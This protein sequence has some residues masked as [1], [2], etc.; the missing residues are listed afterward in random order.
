M[1]GFWTLS[2]ATGIGAT[3]GLLAL[4]LWPFFP[5]DQ[6]WLGWLFLAA[7]MVAGLCGLSILLITAFDILFHPRRGVRIRPVR[8]FDIVLGAALVA[9]S[10]LQL[11]DFAGQLS[12]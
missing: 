7:S 9:L 5:S 8:A 4:L 11:Q 1:L 2:R 10:L 3:A 12:A 6:A